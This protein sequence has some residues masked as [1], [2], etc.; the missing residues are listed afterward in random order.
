MKRIL[1]LT[2]LLFI[3]GAIFSQTMPRRIDLQS[4][5]AKGYEW[6]TG[7]FKNGLYFPQDTLQ[8]SDSG[9]AAIVNGVMY[10][11]NVRH[12]SNIYW[13]PLSG[14]GGSFAGLSDVTISSPKNGQ[15]VVYDS[16]VN[17]WKN[18]P[19]P[20]YNVLDYGI[21]NDSVTD[22]TA[23]L[24]ELFALVPDGASVFFPG[25]GKGYLIS[26][27]IVINKSLNIYGDGDAHYKFYTVVHEPAK[28][29]TNI[30]FASNTK[31]CFI[32]KSSATN[33]NPVITIRDLTIFNNDTASNKPSGAGVL[34][35]DNIGGSNIRNVTIGYFHTDVKV[36]SGNY[37]DFQNCSFI[38][39][40]KYAV[41]LGNIGEVDLGVFKFN[42]ANFFSGY[43]NSGDSLIGVIFRGGGYVD[44]SHC[45]FNAQG[46]YNYPTQF[47]YQLYTTFEQGQTSD[48]IIANNLFENYRTN[49]IRLTNSSGS[50]IYSVKVTGNMISPFNQGQQ[51]YNA[52]FVDGPFIDIALIDNGGHSLVST[53]STSPFAFMKINNCDQLRIQRGT[54]QGWAAYDSVTNSTDAQHVLYGGDEDINGTSTVLLENNNSGSSAVKAIQFKA[55][56]ANGYLYQT[57]P[58]YGFGLGNSLIMQNPTGDVV[59]YGAAQNAT[60]KNDGKVLFGTTSATDPISGDAKFK[61]TDGSMSLTFKD[62]AGQGWL[63]L[64][65]GTMTGLIG[66]TNTTD[67]F[68]MGTFTNHPLNFRTNS[69]NR[70]SI[71]S[72][73]HMLVNTSTDN[74]ELAQFNGNVTVLDDAY[75]P[76]TWNGSLQ[77]PTKNAIRDKIESLSLSSLTDIAFSSLKNGDIPVYDSV[78]LKWKNRKPVYYNVKDYGAVGDSTTDDRAAIIKARNAAYTNGGVLFFPA[79][80]YRIS[81]SI[82]FQYPIRI[83]GVGKSGGLHNNQSGG[84]LEKDRLGPIQT[85]TEIIVTDGKNGFVFDRQAN[86]TKAQYTI[87]NITMSSTVAPGSATG[88][89]FI[90][91]RG[92]LQGA[93]IDKCTFYGGYVQVDIQSGYYQLITGCH[94]SAPQICGVKSGNNIRT[95]TGDFTITACTF[96]S[97]TFARTDTTK[98]IWWHSGGGMRVINNK[99]DAC[100]FNNS[101]NFWYDIYC[102]NTLDPTSDIIISNNSFEN[103]HASAIYMRGIVSPY[104]RNIH[105]TSNQFAPVSSIG[106]A[107]D[108]DRFESIVISDFAIRDWGGPIDAPAIKVTNCI[109]VTI[110]KGEWRDYT[111][112]IDIT[113]T[114]NW[115]MDYMHGGDVAIGSKNTTNIAGLNSSLYTTLTVLG[116]ATSGQ[117][118]AGSVEVA[119]KLPDADDIDVGYLDFTALNNTTNRR[120]ASIGV[121]TDGTTATNRGGKMSFYLKSDGGAFAEKMRITN[122]GTIRMNSYGSG[123]KT[124]TLSKLTGVTSN[125][126]LMDVD[127]AQ[128]LVNFANTD[129]RFTGNRTHSAAGYFLTI[130]SMDYLIQQVRGTA[131]TLLKR[132]V[133][134]NAYGSISK[135]L[136][137]HAQFGD[138]YYKVNGTTDSIHQRLRINGATGIHVE[139]QN[140]SLSQIA[141]LSLYKQHAQLRADSVMIS[142]I[143]TTTG[144]TM[145]VVD[146][147]DATSKTNV[148]KKMA[149]TTKIG[150][151]Q[152]HTSGTS[153][154][155]SNN[156]TR[157]FIDPASALASLDITFPSTPYDGQ[158]IRIF[159]GGTIT[160]GASDVVTGGITALTLPSGAMV[161]TAPIS[162]D[163]VKAGTCYIF[164]Y[165]A[166]GDLWYF[167]K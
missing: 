146:G 135:D 93:V 66:H 161:P 140:T 2:A 78:L 56:S 81:D 45:H 133:M 126:T 143:P 60:F 95:D 18:K 85:S 22:N 62:N 122:D 48:I 114:T 100:E 61:I 152:V 76:S 109:D 6:L 96:S 35:A 52:V 119:T 132:D 49:A 20:V 166:S 106:P 144:D 16:L 102:A 160:S 39:P 167:V 71:T 128:Y 138:V 124:G 26:D 164:E 23:P 89:A 25:W 21:I 165:R 7:S 130:D 1:F 153:V 53:P 74:G 82:L 31:N 59:M 36:R 9:A 13:G 86:E 3:S 92:M 155:I 19:A 121:T 125:G 34:I 134:I 27:S 159:F 136:D 112:F 120:I 101:S 148:V 57:N 47:K 127:P 51:A 118:G 28:G 11:K 90:V 72:G 42:N 151:D 4:I 68:T 147:F 10:L 5:N 12:G 33:K 104:V 94:F 158:Q 141:R 142:A 107:I 123:S 43:H 105:I 115:H 139:Y 163:P 38:A 65:N 97:G 15:I 108:I 70:F 154:T 29:A 116:R 37:V 44:I 113:G 103:W 8:S 64:S 63:S 75:N 67:G 50:P 149:R 73:G 110:G 131:L 79:G 98:A 83:Q 77:I 55:G 30:F 162:S 157:L 150:A 84:T 69:T 41:D 91:I 99:F 156:V 58:S 54:Q 40:W 111:S 137:D 145:L 80:K 14:A 17:K 117:F 46:V 88:G 32:L 129:L 87:E 24:R